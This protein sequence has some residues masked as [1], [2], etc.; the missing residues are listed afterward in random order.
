[1]D[2]DTQ[3]INLALDA[4]E[5][6]LASGADKIYPAHGKPFLPQLLTKNK[7]HIGALILRPLKHK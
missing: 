2:K 4:G 3:L 5:L 7:Q 1:M 6:M